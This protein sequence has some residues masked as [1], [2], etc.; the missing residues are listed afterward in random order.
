MFTPRIISQYRLV[1]YSDPT[2]LPRV[3]AVNP[4][5]AVHIHNEFDV[6]RKNPAE[7]QPLSKNKV[8]KNPVEES[9][10]QMK[11]SG[12]EILKA[13]DTGQHHL[14]VGAYKPYDLMQYE[15]TPVRI[16]VLTEKA[17]PG[18][19]EWAVF[20][21]KLYQAKLFF[22]HIY[23]ENDDK[24]LIEKKWSKLILDI[25]EPYQGSVQYFDSS[26]KVV[27]IRNQHKFHEIQMCLNQY[28][29]NFLIMGHESRNLMDKLFHSDLSEQLLLKM[30]LPML[31]IPRNNSSVGIK[32][33]LVLVDEF[34]FSLD[35]IKQGVQFAADLRA[36]LYFFH[37]NDPSGETLNSFESIKQSLQI[38]PHQ[39]GDQWLIEEGDFFEMI[40]QVIAEH[41][42][43]L[44][45]FGT[46]INADHP[47]SG[48]RT[49]AI[50]NKIAIPCLILHPHL[51]L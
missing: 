22:L 26:P 46:H 31:I 35:A 29:A 45:V 8:T 28:W 17:D 50:I 33:V 32:N 18:L 21:A 47:E 14:R 36:T 9:C 5:D 15:N 4:V 6:D 37:L 24:I 11:G 27:L 42:I 20:L 2:I 16:V 39:G 49:L 25:V 41:Q 40:D 10:F 51:V 13:A 7:V 1:R 19:I 12:G 44:V 34:P 43:D 30:D 3:K 48:Q 38:P 23:D